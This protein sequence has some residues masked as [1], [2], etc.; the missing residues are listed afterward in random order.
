MRYRDVAA[1]AEWLCTA[2]GFEKHSVVKGDDGA[3]AVAQLTVGPTMIML[4]PVGGSELDQLMKQPD[5]IGGAETQVCYFFVADAQDH[6]ARAKAAGAEILFDIEDQTNGGRSYS[7]RDPEGHLWNFGTYDPWRPQTAREDKARWHVQI[8]RGAMSRL[9]LAVGSLIAMAA[10][11]VCTGVLPDAAQKLLREFALLETV[12]I[13]A[14]DTETEQLIRERNAKIAA[15]RAAEEVRKQLAQALS[16]KEAAE[17]AA[18]EVRDQLTQARKDRKMAEQAAE[19][20]RDQL[21][22]AWI[23]KGTAERAAKEARRQ[24]ARERNARAESARPLESQTLLPRW[25]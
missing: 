23:G 6:C 13:F 21:V 16:A 10:I 5:E 12:G 11:V 9:A 2:F 24:L 1:A 15:D 22:R 7:C 25:Q 3:V 14:P 20:A 8:L 4:L 17:H 19:A 18:N